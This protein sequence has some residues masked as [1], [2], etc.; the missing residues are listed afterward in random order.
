VKDTGP[1][2]NRKYGWKLRQ[3]SRNG[4]GEIPVSHREKRTSE[5]SERGSTVKESGC[6]K[7]QPERKGEGGESFRCQKSEIILTFVCGGI[8]HQR[9]NIG[10]ET[11]SEQV[12]CGKD[13]K[14]SEK[15]VKRT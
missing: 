6:L 2:R 3:K 5:Y 8:L 9:L 4:E 13:Q 10:W 12:P 7:L 11:D 1:K 15:R 14:D